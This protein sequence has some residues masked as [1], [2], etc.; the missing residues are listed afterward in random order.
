M[1]TDR[2]VTWSSV[3]R[4]KN[5]SDLNRRRHCHVCTPPQLQAA[6]LTD[7]SVRRCMKSNTPILWGAGLVPQGGG[8][9]APRGR[10]LG[11]SHVQMWRSQWHPSS[12]TLSSERRTHGWIWDCG[13]LLWYSCRIFSSCSKH[14]PIAGLDTGAILNL[15]IKNK[16]QNEWKLRAAEF[17]EIKPKLPFSLVRLWN[18]K[19]SDFLWINMFCVLH[20]EVR[21]WITRSKNR[22]K[23][24]ENR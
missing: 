9:R 2:R 1:Q 4:L 18:Y 14:G 5:L 17:T 16:D 13:S 15:Q 12:T 8:S 22:N 10:V 23:Q 3:C 11:G 6:T 7:M 21:H 24:V 20:S 19:G